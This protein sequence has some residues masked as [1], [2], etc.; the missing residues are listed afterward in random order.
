V[1]SSVILLI[2]GAGLLVA[3]LAVAS[4]SVFS[5]TK[6]ILEGGALI[7]AASL[8]P[9]LGYSAVLKELP[10]GRQLV[11]SLDGE[12]DDVPLSAVITEADGD[13]IGVFN[14]TSTPYTTSVVT[15]EPGDHTLE[16]RNVGTQTVVVNGALLNSPITGEGGGVSVEDDPGLRELA[17]YGVGIL[18]GAALIIAGIVLLIIGAVKHFRSG[19]KP[20]SVPSG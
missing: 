13:A 17:T 6:Q 15:R 20:E 14:V 18:A 2:I 7:E 8:E 11:L 16:L 19:K 4:V 10:E 9:G 5:I 12:P 1:K 3:G